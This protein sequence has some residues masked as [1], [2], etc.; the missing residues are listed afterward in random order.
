MTEVDSVVDWEKKH[1]DSDGVCPLKHSSR[2]VP[3]EVLSPSL[4]F[5]NL[6]IITIKPTTVNNLLHVRVMEEIAGS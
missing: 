3:L 1:E 5:V 2:F 4:N 6:V